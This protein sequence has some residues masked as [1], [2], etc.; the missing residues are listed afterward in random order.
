MFYLTT[1]AS[2]VSYPCFSNEA[3]SHFALQ[4]VARVSTGLE[5]VIEALPAIVRRLPNFLFFIAG[6]RMQYFA[7]LSPLGA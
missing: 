2:R 5:V 4:C 7:C 6:T 3:V 1:T